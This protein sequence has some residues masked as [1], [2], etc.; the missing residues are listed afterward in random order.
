MPGETTSTRTL[1]CA[2]SAE[3][4]SPYAVHVRQVSDNKRAGVGEGVP[5]TA[6]LVVEYA[7]ARRSGHDQSIVPALPY[8]VCI[9]IPYK[10]RP[11]GQHVHRCKND[12]AP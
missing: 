7:P 8:T 3:S 6:A 11:L 1:N 2:S 10:N 5:W 4:V 9:P 12:G